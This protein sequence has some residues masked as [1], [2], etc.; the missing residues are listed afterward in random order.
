MYK[1]ILARLTALA[2]MINLTCVGCSKQNTEISKSGTYFDTVITITLY[3]QAPEILDGCFALAQKYDNYFSTTTPSSDI[4][5]IN[6]HAGEFVSVHSDT[7]KLIEESIHYS[8]ITDG[9]FDITVGHLSKL[10]KDAILSHTVPS[11]E[12]VQRAL[13]TVDYHQI[14]IDGNRIRIGR[15]QALDLGGIAKGYIAD[16]IKAYL[17]KHGIKSGLI[18]LGG[19]IY[20]MSKKPNGDSYTVGIKKPFTKTNEVIDSVTVTNKSVV[21]SGNYERYFKKNDTIYHHIIDLKT[22]YP[23][24]N[25]L[26]SVTIISEKSIDGDALSTSLFL[27][28]EADSQKVIDKFDNLEVRFINKD[29][30]ESTRRNHASY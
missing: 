11:D 2:L 25:D 3:E 21:T 28:G 23:C 12:S 4:A 9:N 13:A 7:R 17:N 5:K 19:N 18:N 1:R 24:Q 27:M 10:W 6:S 26:N 14:E 22:G 15:N 30:Q 20:A 8:K 29:N 16:R